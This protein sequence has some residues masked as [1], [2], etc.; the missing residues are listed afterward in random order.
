[1]LSKQAGLGY[2]L[3][4]AGMQTV[5]R[6]EYNLWSSV[7]NICLSVWIGRVCANECRQSAGANRKLQDNQAGLF[8]VA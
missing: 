2:L 8:P 1:M 5:L 6:P 4:D 3:Q 7:V